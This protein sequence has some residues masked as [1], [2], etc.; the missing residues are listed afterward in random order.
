[1]SKAY[2]YIDNSNVYKEGCRISAVNKSFQGIKNIKE[3]IN[4]G[5]IDYGWYLNYVELYELIEK[6]LQ[7]PL[8]FAKL[9]GSPVQYIKTQK[10]DVMEFAGNILDF[11][12]RRVDIV[13][14]HRM[15]K[16]AYSGVI[17]KENDIMILLAGDIAYVPLIDGLVSD[18][19][20]VC[21][22]FWDHIENELRKKASA[23][24]SLNRYFEK[25]TK[26]SPP[27]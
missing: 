12:K 11:E 26:I 6:L 5:I 16:D 18:G 24:I 4:R 9:W 27:F 8:A 7:V 10:F 15:T 3:A 21:I 22:L 17:D 25:L 23:F 19:F 1:M 14:T 2:V 20:K 13:I